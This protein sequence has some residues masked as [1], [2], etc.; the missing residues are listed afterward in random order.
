MD[1][2]ENSREAAVKRLKAK[3]DFKTHVAAYLIVNTMLVVIWAVAGGGGYFWPIWPI[4]GWGIGLVL[5]GWRVYF[6]RP[7]TEDEIRRE[8]ERGT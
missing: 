8:M 6:Q 5:D 2:V 4:L 3:Q 7:I 1:D